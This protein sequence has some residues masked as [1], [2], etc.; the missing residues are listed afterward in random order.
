MGS[1][2]TQ[3]PMRSRI[4]VID[5]DEAILKLVSRALRSEYDT[6]VEA[7]PANALLT[8]LTGAVFEMILC[9]VSMPG[10]SG[11]ELH[12]AVLAEKP[13]TAARFVL[14]TGGGLSASEEQLLR[15]RHVHNIAKPFTPDELRAFARDFLK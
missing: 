8:L 7:N 14:M 11:I 4:L 6:T 1:G 12:A 10:T 15:S 2:S 13:E 5:D 3:S 9:D